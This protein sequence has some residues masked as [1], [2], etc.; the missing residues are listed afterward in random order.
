MLRDA[1][2]CMPGIER[3][4]VKVVENGAVGGNASAVANKLAAALMARR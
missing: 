4:A 2:N 3:P 1:F